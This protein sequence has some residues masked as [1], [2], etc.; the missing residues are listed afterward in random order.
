MDGEKRKAL[1]EVLLILAENPEL[2]ESIHLK[3]NKILKQS[4]SKAKPKAKPKAKT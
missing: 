3:P 4:P 2:V 1:R